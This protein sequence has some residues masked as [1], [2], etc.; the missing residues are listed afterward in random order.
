MEW[1]RRLPRAVWILTRGLFTSIFGNLSLVALSVALALSLWLFVTNAEN[2]TE[3]QTFNSAIEIGF[4][5]VPTGL[6][7]ANSS[8]NTVRIDIEAPQDDLDSLR[9]DD[10]TADVNLGGLTA[11]K[12]TVPVSVRTTKGDVRIVRIGPEQVEVTLEE[13][14]TKEVPVRVKPLGS[15]QQGFSAGDQTADPATATVSGPQSLVELVDAAVAQPE[16]TGLRVD[17]TNDR[18]TLRPQDARGGEIGRV[19][20]SPETAGVA[21]QIV[22][23]E[24]SLEFVVNPSITGRPAA[25][26]NVAGISVDPSVVT[27]T[28]PLEELQSLDAIAGISTGEV[29]IGDARAT[30]TRQ[31]ALTL[32]AGIGVIGSNQV[33]V[34]I[35]I[36]PARGEATFLV[37]PQVR[38]VGDGLAVT[39]GGSVLVTLSGDVAALQALSP[40]SIIALADA[41]GLEAG[42]HIVPLAV[43]PPSDTTVVRVDPGEFG[44]ALTAR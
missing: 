17:F 40:E 5:N 26:F 27:L 29:A 39:P 25:G 31:V 22:Q 28:G 34:T 44:I 38:N 9:A 36:A 42:L 12:A 1:S 23:R 4:T 20:V 30:F 10:F 24:F 2:P 35:N 6:A 16:L 13:L 7:V 18:M 14:R 19:T 21:V 37:A 33:L 41:Q 15:P 8:A 3:R 32:P 11:G 43:T